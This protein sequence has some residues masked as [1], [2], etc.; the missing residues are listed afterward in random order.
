MLGSCCREQ[1]S[2][3]ARGLDRLCC[4]LVMPGS[5]HPG[6]GVTAGHFK[7]EQSWLWGQLIPCSPQGMRSTEEPCPCLSSWFLRQAHLGWPQTQ[8]LG[9][10]HPPVPGDVGSREQPTWCCCCS[11]AQTVGGAAV[12]D[13]SFPVSGVWAGCG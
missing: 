1:G 11:G 12:R 7:L 13:G 3:L 5:A 10:L 9:P 6:L 4:A 2:L 8:A